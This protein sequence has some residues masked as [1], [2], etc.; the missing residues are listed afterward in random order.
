L[1]NLKKI[2]LPFFL[3]LSIFIT[4]AQ[5]NQARA[6]EPKLKAFLIVSGYGAGGGALLG[7][8][9]MAFG[10]KA[11]AIAQGASL[12][13]YAGMLFGG[14]AILSYK[15][16]LNAPRD[17]YRDPITPYRDTPYGGGSYDG[18]FFGNPRE[19]APQY[20]MDMDFQLERSAIRNP[21]L[22]GS[23]G[24]DAPVY[25]DIVKIIF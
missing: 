14:Y 24:R 2:M 8:A 25:L 5:F 13:L 12:G 20:R 22:G 15:Y 7:L 3:M 6:M 17:E 23:V 19:D 10:A 11:R 18:D 9:S 4:S 1:L 16:R 21:L